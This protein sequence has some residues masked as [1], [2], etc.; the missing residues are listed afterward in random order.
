MTVH[1]ERLVI[2]AANIAPGGTLVLLERLYGALADAGFDFKLVVRARVAA[3][4]EERHVVRYDRFPLGRACLLRRVC[5]AF[6]CTRVLHFGNLAT[7]RPLRGIRQEVY[8]HNLNIAFPDGGGVNG[9][10]ARLKNE[11][12]A[13]WS[14]VTRRHVA[15]LYVQS[16]Y[17]AE[18]VQRRLGYPAERVY[19][20]AFYPPAKPDPHYDGGAFDF[21][22]PAAYYPHKN[23]DLLFAALSHLSRSQGL[24]PRVALIAEHSPELSGKIEACTRDG[25]NVCRLGPLS[26]AAC[27][28][29]V[30]ASGGLVFPSLLESLGLP[31]VEAALLGR[32]I[33]CA[34]LPYAHAAVIPSMVFPPLSVESLA[35]CMA[36][37]IHL[38]V[39]P[40]RLRARDQIHTLLRDLEH[41]H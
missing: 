21:V 29:V 18:A 20:R 5:R 23:H 16:A 1:R 12:M 3:C 38:G 33:I 39:G 13:A 4:F 11:L 37:A 9:S 30:A 2:D 10:R 32:P 28:S 35:G 14:R 27:M 7:L 34:D 41:R 31:L 17:V 6:G 24:R 22:Y 40:G 8:F 19:V 25:G 26:H 15:R 36:V